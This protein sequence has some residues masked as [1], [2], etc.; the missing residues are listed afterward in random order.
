MLGLKRQ[1]A[2]LVSYYCA[3][4]TKSAIEFLATYDYYSHKPSFWT[5][6]CLVSS[7]EHL[8]ALIADA[9]CLVA[10]VETSIDPEEYTGPLASRNLLQET[11]SLFDSFQHFGK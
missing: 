7:E 6:S 10:F 11:Q 2:L 1:L 3:L 9:K 5:A 8:D 4:L